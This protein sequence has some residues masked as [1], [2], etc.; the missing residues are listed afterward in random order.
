MAAKKRR[1]A[2]TGRTL[3]AISVGR[4]KKGYDMLLLRRRETGAS[5]IPS[6]MICGDL[7]GDGDVDLLDFGQFQLAF[8]GPL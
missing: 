1:H 4:F 2:R 5:R 8:T 6:S 3:G 7:D